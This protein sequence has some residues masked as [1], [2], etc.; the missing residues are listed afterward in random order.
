[1]KIAIMGIRGI[2]ANYSG[3]ETFAEGF[4]LR[5]VKRGYE[6]TVYNR[7]N[8]INYN[9]RFYNGIRLVKLPTIAN[10]YLDTIFHT[11]LSLIHGIFRRYDI[12]YICGVG[13][14]ILA[15]IPR[16]FNL[17]VVLNVDGLDWQRGKWGILARLYL[18]LSEYLA[19]KFAN[20]IISDSQVIQRYYLKRYNKETVYIPYG[21]DEN[22]QSARARQGLAI[23]SRNILERFGLNKDKY[24][25]FVGRLVP[26]NGAHY[27]IKAYCNLKTN[28]KLVIV[29]DAPYSKRY[30]QSLKSCENRNVIFTG[31]LFG[32]GYRELSSNAYLF[33][34]PSN[35]GGSRPVLLEQM[36]LGNCVLVSDSEPNLETVG[37]AGIIYKAEEL[38]RDL[39]RKL[40]YLLDNPDLVKEYRCK[41]FEH[42]KKHYSWE[43]VIKRYEDL[44][45]ELLR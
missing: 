25:L 16:L 42:V 15:F 41:A 23:Y 14:S 11:F 31:Y 5:L 2:P 33:I 21:V 26:E 44:F 28:L 8:W 34:L 20:V 12:I 27:L 35:V 13:N 29:G 40:R 38:N 17:R 39:E 45:V 4:G 19:S 30:I 10:K 9:E 3:F 7:S 18:K 37:D 6:V 32:E 36:A 43:T 1:M 24:I 22:C